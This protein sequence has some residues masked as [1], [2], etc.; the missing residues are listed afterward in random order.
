MNKGVWYAMGA[1]TIWGSFP[2]TGNGC[3]TCLRCKF[4][5]HRIVW[6]FLLLAIV[7]IVRAAVACFPCRSAALAHRSAFTS[8]PRCC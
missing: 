3:M 7:L 2:F 5:A 6:S 8:S 1:Y 4:W